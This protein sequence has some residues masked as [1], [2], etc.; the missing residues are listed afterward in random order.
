[1]ENS[2]R[3]V[4]IFICPGSGELMQP[5][6][7]AMA[8]AGAGLDGDRYAV[9]TGKYSGRENRGKP[10]QCVRDVTFISAYLIQR[11]NVKLVEMGLEPFGWRETRRNIVVGGGIDLLS[12]IG[13]KFSSG[14]VVFE[15]FEDCTPCV[16][17]NELAKKE[18]FEVAFKTC[19]G[20]RAR[21]LQGGELRA[22]GTL[23]F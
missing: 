22:G 9:G 7:T 5:F 3:I 14:E 21:I 17:P 4:A 23:W 19:G 13:K 1:M 12:L 6:E 18:K 15:G 8:I 20:L 11:A 16:T 10:G 2:S